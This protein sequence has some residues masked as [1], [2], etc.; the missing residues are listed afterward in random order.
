M[1]QMRDV[2]M[3]IFDTRQLRLALKRLFSFPSH[4]PTGSRY[5]RLDT[6]L[7]GTIVDN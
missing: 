3:H 4:D 6:K 1:Q 5:R 7:T 2:K